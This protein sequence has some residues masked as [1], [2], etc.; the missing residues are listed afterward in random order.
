MYKANEITVTTA[1][2]TLIDFGKLF[3]TWG[4]YPVDGNITLQIKRKDTADWG[5][6]IYG[7]QGVGLGDDYQGTALR[8]KAVT[9]SVKVGYYISA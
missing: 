7:Y 6:T 4:V 5:D 9:G 8:V 3:S 2:W 1:D